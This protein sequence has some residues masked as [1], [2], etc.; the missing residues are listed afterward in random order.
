MDSCPAKS[1]C[2]NGANKCFDVKKDAGRLLMN[3]IHMYPRLQ[4]DSSYRY[5]VN[6][7]EDGSLVW[8]TRRERG[9]LPVPEERAALM[10]F[11]R[12][13][14]QAAV[15]DSVPASERD[16]VIESLIGNTFCVQAVTYLLGSWL[17]QVGALAAAIPGSSCLGVGTCE[18]NWNVV[19]DFQQ[20]GHRDPQLERSLI[21][22]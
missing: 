7:Y 22:P 6:N 1:P 4:R 3:P 18:A 10:G 5:Q 15:K 12:L 21:Q 16:S 11:D 9:R 8:D 20:P 13:Y 14:F 17:A 19:P 2:Q